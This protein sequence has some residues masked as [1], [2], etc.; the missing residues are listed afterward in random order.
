MLSKLS[1]LFL[2][3]SVTIST[4]W[5]ASVVIKDGQK[6]AFL[7]DSITAQGWDVSGG[8]VK[9]VTAGL[10][11]I[12]VKIIPIPAG[13]SGNTSADMLGRLGR[14]VLS[15][16]P[17]WLTLSCGVND[18]WHGING[19]ALEPYKKNITAIVDQAQAAGIKVMILTSTVIG[20]NDNDNNT[21]LIAYNDFL[22]KLANERNLPLADEN[23][24]FQAALKSTPKRG[25]RP[26]V[27]TNDGVHPNP[28][29]HQLMAKTIVAAF[30][31]TPDDLS[32]VEQAWLDT[33]DSANISL[34]VAFQATGITIREFETLK[35]ASANAHRPFSGFCEDLYFQALEESIKAHGSDQSASKAQIQT[36]AQ[37]RFAQKL[38]TLSKS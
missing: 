1:S 5:S 11:T 27:L 35:S 7:G 33:P 15:K 23:A 17:D 38:D 20:E 12:G 28:D 3:L 30:G 4:G 37:K 24:A 32:K 18:V 9:L 19:V 21:K 22:R 2:F 16:K 13:V 34:V 8:Y 31:A 25:D 36:D 6:V 10:Q 26:G 14:D 29:G